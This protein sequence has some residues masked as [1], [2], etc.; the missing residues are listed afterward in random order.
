MGNLFAA[1][2]VS[3]VQDFLVAGMPTLLFWRMKIPFRQK[4]ALG[5]VFAVGFVLCFTAIVRFIFSYR[6]YF[7]SYDVTWEAYYGWLFTSI[8]VLLGCIVASAP[9]L[10][11]FFRRYL[12]TRFTYYYDDNNYGAGGTRTE[13]SFNRS[14]SGTTAEGAHNVANKRPHSFPQRISRLFSGVSSSPSEQRH[15]D[16]KRN[17]KGPSSDPESSSVARTDAQQS[18][19]FSTPLKSLCEAGDRGG[20]GRVNEEEPSALR[21][22][23][24]YDDISLNP[25]MW[26]GQAITSSSPSPPP[27][28][29]MNG[30]TSSD[31]DE[32][33]PHNSET[34]FHAK[35]GTQGHSWSRAEGTSNNVSAYSMSGAATTRTTVSGDRKTDG[36]IREA[37]NTSYSGETVGKPSP[38]SFGTTGEREHRDVTEAF[39]EPIYR[40]W[41]EGMPPH[42]VPSRRA[43]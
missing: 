42:S 34:W 24:P 3:T 43:R 30:R 25:E 37:P 41:V 11:V 35:D 29:D 18:S 12:L 20:S 33:G 15:W 17:H 10:K 8:E 31:R 28:E 32:P 40:S 26:I 16:E 21:M 4:V 7:A 5:A 22:G 2:V 38:A 9:A 23:G 13:G 36:N 6:V 14:L 19:R 1:S 39:S 27:G